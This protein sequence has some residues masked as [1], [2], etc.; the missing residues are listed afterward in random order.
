MG[1]T[2]T[3]RARSVG[4]TAGLIRE[5]QEEFVALLRELPPESWEQPSLCQGWSVRDVVLHTAAHIHNE[6]KDKAVLRQ[7]AARPEA[8]LVAWLASP[9]FE[10]NARAASARSR[11]AQIQR[12]ELMIH[13]Q[14]VRRALGRPRTIP[15][16]RVMEVLDYGLEPFGSFTLAFGRSRAKGVRLVSTESDWAWGHGPESRGTL[17]AILMATSGRVAALAELEGPGVPVL[18]ARA[19]RPPFVVRKAMAI[20]AKATS[21][22]E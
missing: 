19:E 15:V 14:D 20:G 21:Y 10:S 3:Q 12:G 11:S 13:Q 16:D 18:R 6:Q 4:L 2:G 7:Y 1:T 22:E 9:P 17:E 8:D 5:E